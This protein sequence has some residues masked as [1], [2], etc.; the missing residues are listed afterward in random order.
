MIL[1]QIKN[2]HKYT[3]LLGDLNPVLGF[4]EQTLKERAEPGQYLI[5]GKEL[6][7]NIDCAIAKEKQEAKLEAHKHYIDIQICLQGDETIG[8]R[9]LDKCQSPAQKFNEEKDFIFY[10]DPI[11]TWIQV[12]PKHFT[13]FFPNDAHAPMVGEGEFYKLVF[14]VAI[15]RSLEI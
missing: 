7:V 3:S 1:D 14:K 6:F 11:E 4:Y 5:E 12:P 9:A 13:V 15:D 10:N 8:W 2:L